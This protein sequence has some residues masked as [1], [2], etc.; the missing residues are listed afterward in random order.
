MT[1]HELTKRDNSPKPH[2][3]KCLACI[4]E[5]GRTRQALANR[6][7][8]WFQRFVGNAGLPRVVTETGLKLNSL[9]GV[10]GGVT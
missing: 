7:M 10:S 6:Q 3:D 2:Y 5:R 1:F 8:A 9:L 4:N